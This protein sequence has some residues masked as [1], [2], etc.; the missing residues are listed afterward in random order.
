MLF[1]VLG[2][3]RVQISEF[4]IENNKLAKLND[5]PNK[6]TLIGQIIAEP[7]ARDT[8]QK[9]KVKIGESIILVTAQRYP[10][11]YYLDTIK[12]TG[13]LKT[14]IVFDSFN[15][16]NYLMKD[17]IYSVMDF[18]KI[19]LLSICEVKM[20]QGQINGIE[21]GNPNPTMI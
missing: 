15:Y 18:P 13:K 11:Y 9:L 5:A 4:S 21:L 2:I 16:K 20:N 8:S 17:G 19:E 14:P 12:I 10:E 7:D 6:I 1:L 3:T